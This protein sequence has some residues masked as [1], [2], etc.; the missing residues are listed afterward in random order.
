MTPKP[1]AVGLMLCGQTII[2]KDTGSP[3]AI[4]IFTGLAVERFPSDPQR[5]SVFGVLTD[6]QGSGRLR[7]AVFRLDQHWLRQEEIYAGQYPI[8]FPDRFAVVNVNL[9]LR[10]IRFPAA[11]TYEFVLFVD[12]D[13]VAHRRTR[14]YQGTPNTL[15]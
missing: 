3:S 14:V 13:E 12:A 6:A 10:Q 8:R 7:L 11:G 1:V 15:G 5:F 4:G 2:D 9:R